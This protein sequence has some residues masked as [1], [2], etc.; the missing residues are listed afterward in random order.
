[1]A[2]GHG[3]YVEHHRPAA[4]NG[5][6]F[7]FFNALTGDTGQWEAPIAAP[8]RKAGHGT[9][10]FNFKGQKDSP[11]DPG[12]TVDAASITGDAV[13]VIQAEAPARPYA[14]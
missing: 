2:E 1:M 10:L 9:L 6:T 7:V 13:R 8:L 14:A 3:L 11:L 4:G 12:A 5:L